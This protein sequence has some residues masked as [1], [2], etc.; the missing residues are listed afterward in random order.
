[1]TIF[2][3]TIYSFLIIYFAFFILFWTG[4]KFTK[5]FRGSRKIVNY[6][7]LNHSWAFFSNPHRTNKN[8]LLNIEYYDGEKELINLFDC[9]NMIFINRKANTFDKKY[10]SN[11]THYLQLRTIFV[12]YIK[13]NIEKNKNKK[14][15]KI[16][17]LEK[18]KKIK[19]WESNFETE[20]CTISSHNF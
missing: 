3:N 13:K 15:K 1:M 18:S 17:F 8:L 6:L 9:E 19:L 7:C 11:M 2:I 5:M 20:I 16:E 14:I 12:Y 4:F 10:A